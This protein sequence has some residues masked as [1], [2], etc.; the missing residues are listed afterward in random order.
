MATPEPHLLGGIGAIPVN[1]NRERTST[2][3]S[4]P[5][6]GTA[7]PSRRH[8]RV[9][10]VNKAAGAKIAADDAK[11]S[12]AHLTDDALIHKLV[13]FY[14]DLN[15]DKLTVALY[16]QIQQMVRQ[17]TRFAPQIEAAIRQYDKSIQQMTREQLGMYVA[18]APQFELDYAVFVMAQKDPNPRNREALVELQHGG[19]PR[20]V[21]TSTEW[22]NTKSLSVNLLKELLYGIV[23]SVGV[24]VGTLVTTAALTSTVQGSFNRVVSERVLGDDTWTTYIIWNLQGYGTAVTEGLR[25]VFGVLGTAASLPLK[26]ALGS[27]FTSYFT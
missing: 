26:A 18:H 19:N 9:L 20:D 17:R 5:A 15:A 22:N 12:V 2:S 7:L 16:K 25:G 4:A 21:L 13:V 3:T 14:T 11:D 24:A 1:T 6:L 27:W 23:K 10:S 8:G